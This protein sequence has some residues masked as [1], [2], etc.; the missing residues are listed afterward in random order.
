MG[1]GISLRHR[2]LRLDRALHGFIMRNGTGMLERDLE[3][4]IAGSLQRVVESGISLDHV[5]SP[6]SAATH[7]RVDGPTRRIAVIVLDR[8]NGAL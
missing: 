1:L 4:P 7:R 2:S 8:C 3:L 5:F 6:R